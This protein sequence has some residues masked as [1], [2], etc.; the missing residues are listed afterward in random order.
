MIQC[1][2]I[3]LAPALMNNP[4]E[5]ATFTIPCRH[6]NFVGWHRGR[7]FYA[8]WLIMADTAAIR[9]AT[10]NLRCAMGDWLLPDYRRQPHITLGIRGFPQ[11][12]QQ[13]EHSY[14][15]D[16]FRQDIAQLRQLP[17]AA[18]S[19]TCQGANSFTTAPYLAVTSGRE[20]LLDWHHILSPRHTGN[21]YIPHITAGFYRRAIPLCDIHD[22]LATFSMQSC[23]LTASRIELA[24][25]ASADTAGRL[26]TICRFDL[27]S[28]QLNIVRPHLLPWLSG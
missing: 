21:P 17:R 28:R 25:Y 19:L 4:P 13:D 14:T 26:Q 12:R 9:E 7:P 6:D 18:L 23:A 10:H 2:T 15:P 5:T 11:C 8:A 1:A 20:T 22:A 24:A 27:H 16:L 3:R